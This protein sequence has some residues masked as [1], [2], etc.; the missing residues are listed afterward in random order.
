MQVLDAGPQ[1]GGT[2]P[3]Y[4]HQGVRLPREPSRMNRLRPPATPAERGAPGGRDHHPGQCA[5]AGSLGRW[6]ASVSRTR[7]TSGDLRGADTSPSIPNR[8]GPL[9]RDHRIPLVF[10]EAGQRAQAEQA[11]E[12]VATELLKV[13][14]AAVIAMNHSVLVETARRFVAAFYGALAAGQRVGQATLAGQR[15]CS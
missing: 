7:A 4:N 9:R 3:I 1:M 5:T 10:L 15:S 6:S 12:S 2:R 14:V 11:S 8:L 13:G